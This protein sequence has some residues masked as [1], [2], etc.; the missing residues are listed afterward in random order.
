MANK[1]TQQTN[2]KQLKPEDLGQVLN[3]VATEAAMVNAGA[4][5]PRVTELPN[6]T[7]VKDF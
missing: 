4:K 6:G 7:I 3:S 2:P 1:P 5:E